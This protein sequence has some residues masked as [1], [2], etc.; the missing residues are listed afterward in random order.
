MPVEGIRSGLL[1]ALLRRYPTARFVLMHLAYPYSGELIALAK[2]YPNV[3]IDL[4]WSWSI[5]PYS[6]CDALRRAIHAV[7]S[8]KIF[9]F[10]GDTHLPAPAVAY[11]AQAR[12]WLARALQA[13]VN[14][15]LLTEYAAIR[16]ASR[17]M[18]DNQLDCFDIAGRRQTIARQPR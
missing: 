16:L 13:E 17:L 7:P 1:T 8:H 5:D 4:C 2:H 14:D 6:A 9:A 15:G 12:H 10:G 11:A 18:R 3:Y